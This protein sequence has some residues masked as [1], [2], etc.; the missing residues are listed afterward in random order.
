VTD[1]VVRALYNEIE[2]FAIEWLENLSEAGH[3][4]R[5]VVDSRS[6]KSIS[7]VTGV[8]AHFFA[9]LGGWSRALRLARW[10]D[11]EPVWTG[12]CPCQPFSQA[13]KGRGFDDDR[14]LWPDWFRL[15][16]QHNPAIIFGE[17][18]AS[19]DGLKWF[20]LVSTDLE[21]AGYS[22][23]AADLCAASVGAPHIR[24]RL[25]FV[26]VSNMQRL[27][28]FG[29]RLLAR[30]SQQAGA[31][32]TSVAIELGDT[33]RERSRWDAGAIPC[34]EG[35]SPSERQ[36]SGRELDEFVD[37]SCWS[38]AE[39]IVCQDG[40]ARSVEPGTHPLAYGV[41][42]R[43]GKLRAYGNAIVPQVAATFIRAVME[44]L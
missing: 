11:D 31:R 21:S 35:E 36:Q 44:V 27:E 22:V 38:N 41:P 12:S 10:P 20:D 43:V 23:G 4:A 32:Q 29:L 42:A 9:G 33:S 30:Q 3:I 28:R 17:Q 25:Y 5:G 6:I 26:A 19:P 14:H 40:K 24:Q 16:V 18:V 15:I 13:G 8:Q 1:T 39:W 7:D 34:E 2:P 37:A